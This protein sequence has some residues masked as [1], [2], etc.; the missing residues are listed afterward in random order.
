MQTFHLICY[1]IA[2]IC[3]VIATLWDGTYRRVDGP[4]PYTRL[5]LIGLGLFA[6]VLV[7]L[8]DTI[9]AY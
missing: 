2:A 7:P 9:K 6:W 8:V 4:G 5:N 3:F 1:I